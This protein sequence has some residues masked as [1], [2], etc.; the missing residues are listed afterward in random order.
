MQVEATKAHAAS[1]TSLVSDM[2]SGLS[3]GELACP[4]VCRHTTPLASFRVLIHAATSTFRP[5]M[6]EIEPVYARQTMLAVMRWRDILVT[7][8]MDDRCPRLHPTRPADPGGARYQSPWD[9]GG[10]FTWPNSRRCLVVRTE[11]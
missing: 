5:T 10:S 6:V 2:H 7:I 9:G 4:D 11:R 3:A 1:L 8:G